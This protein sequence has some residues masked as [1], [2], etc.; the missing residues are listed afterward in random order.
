MIVGTG[1][2]PPHPEERPEGSRLEGWATDAVLVPIL[3]G[4]SS[5]SARKRLDALRAPQDEVVRFDPTQSRSS[6]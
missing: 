2:T 6:G 4:V 5:A 3:L 1:I